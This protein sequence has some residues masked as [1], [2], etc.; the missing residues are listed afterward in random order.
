MTRHRLNLNVNQAHYSLTCLEEDTAIWITV[1]MK[2]MTYIIW[3]NIM[4]YPSQVVGSK[5]EP[6]LVATPTLYRK[7]S[8]P[9]LKDVCCSVPNDPLDTKAITANVIT[10]S[11]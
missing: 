11:A 7:L 4:I 10:I 8:T 6:K 3:N 1:V 9:L 5:C 2:I